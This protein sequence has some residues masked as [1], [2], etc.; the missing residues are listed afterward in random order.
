MGILGQMPQEGFHT[1]RVSSNY[2]PVMPAR[3]PTGAMLGPPPPYAHPAPALS[4]TPPP[5]PGASSNSGRQNFGFGHPSGQGYGFWQQVEYPVAHLDGQQQGGYHGGHLE[6]HLSVQQGGH[7]PGQQDGH[8]PGQQGG[9]L[10]GQQGGHLGGL[11]GEGVAE[12]NQQ[13]NG[14]QGGWGGAP[15]GSWPQG[16]SPATKRHRHH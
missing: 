12:G 1:P 3:L 9:Y 4:E 8:L 7:L 6:D 14:G 16:E 2:V 13:Q 11:Q 5:T 10:P 15:Q